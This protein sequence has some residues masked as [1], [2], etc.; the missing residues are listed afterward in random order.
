MAVFRAFFGILVRLT[1]VNL[2]GAGIAHKAF[3]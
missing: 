1:S 3:V 2:R